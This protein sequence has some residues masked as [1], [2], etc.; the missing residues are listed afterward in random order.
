MSIES[1]WRDIERELASSPQV[2]SSLRPPAARDQLHRWSTA[3]GADL[4]EALRDAYLVHDGTTLTGAGGFSFIAEWYPLPVER[5]IQ[6]HASHAE[7]LQL[8]A[9]PNLVP[10]AVDPGGSALALSFDGSDDLYLILD[11]APP[12]PYTFH[13]FT[14]LAGLLSATV[15]G[16]QGASG[17]YRPEL[18]ERH[19]S[20]IN[21]EEEADD[22]GY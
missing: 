16:L 4:P 13:E 12:V 21:L 11:D 17:D 22:L 7:Y 6:R 20:W 9:S 10:F 1:L 19:L 18:D 2:L 15:T 5:A 8:V 14:T 3:V